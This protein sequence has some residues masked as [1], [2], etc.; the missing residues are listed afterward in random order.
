MSPR[1]IRIPCSIGLALLL[2]ACHHA[3]PA[4]SGPADPKIDGET[5][6]LEAAAI[7]AGG[8]RAE[9]VTIDDTASLTLPGRIAWDE[10]RTVRVYSP[11]S[12]R[13]VQI[14]AKPGDR[15]AAG[16]VL[17]LLSS[18]DYGSAQADLRKAEAQA[19][20]AEKANL[21]ARD[22]LEH[23]VIAAKDAEQAT[24]D[25]ANAQA[26]LQRA[27]ARLRLF[28]DAA[29]AVDQLYR[30]RAPIAGTVVDKALNPGQEVFADQPGAPLFTITDPSALWVVLDGQ[31]NALAGLAPGL[32]FSIETPAYPGERFAA[33]LLQIA[34]SLDPQTRTIKLRG[35]VTN[36]DRRL[37][38]EMF[39]SA[40]LR[41]DVAALPSV[42]AAAVFLDGE[43]N[44]V[45]VASGDGA[46]TRR[47]I[48]VG[49]ERSGRVPVL[50]GLKTG[51]AVV[52]AGN[53][54]LQQLLH[55]HAS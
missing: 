3:A 40:T 44:E 35:R 52:T 32:A 13:I 5:V 29:P 39:V 38:G 6:T 22:L 34:D 28:G 1:M 46:Y 10:D 19:T 23:G 31:D 7:A 25:A 41:R 2:A 36:T 33:E 30:L 27:Q 11:F 14:L 54:Y 49:A 4:E 16:Q 45:F 20:L 8:I 47:A 48:R 9:P 17:A 53:L 18:A 12:G 37:K 21:R 26:E 42:P 43:H 24:A 15:V 51:D 50:E 55:A